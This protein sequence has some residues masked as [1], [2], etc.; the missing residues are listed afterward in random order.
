MSL[1]KQ[2]WAIFQTQQNQGID[3][4]LASLTDPEEA[5]SFVERTGIDCLAVS[6][7]NVHLL[8]HSTAQIDLTR[9]TAIQEHISVPL[10][11]HGGP[12]SHPN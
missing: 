10:V 12:D 7:G 1:S 5:A 4:S 8:T 11:I 2:N 3:A 9:L 6:I